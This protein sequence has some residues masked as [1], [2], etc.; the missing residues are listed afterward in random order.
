M[1]LTGTRDPGRPGRPGR[2]LHLPG[3]LDPDHRV[4]QPGR[5]RRTAP[6]PATCSGRS[7]ARPR[8]APTTTFVG[9]VMALTS[10]TL[11]TGATVE[12]R[13]LAR[14]GQVALDNNTFTRPSCATTRR[15]RRLRRPTSGTPTGTPSPEPVATLRPARRRLATTTRP[16]AATAAQRRGRRWRRRRHR[17]RR[18]RHRRRAPAAGPPAG[19]FVP[20]G[21]PETGAR[22]T[23]RAPSNA[24]LGLG[25]VCLVG[26]GAAARRAQKG[27]R[28]Q[29]RR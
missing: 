25:V 4:G 16:V 9:T 6:S 8:S 10:I 12:G 27:H 23:D 15:A 26:A 18:H 21:H 24:W 11:Q 14:N 2:G 19:P 1:A 20:T 3:R 22:S 7:A 13:M 5:A 17:R 28:S 29:H